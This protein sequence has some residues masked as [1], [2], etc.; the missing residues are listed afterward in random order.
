M[1]RQIVGLVFF[2]LAHFGGPVVVMAGCPVQP[3]S[4][5]CPGRGRE[6][7]HPSHSNTNKPS[8]ISGSTRGVHEQCQLCATTDTHAVR[9]GPGGPTVIRTVRVRTLE[10]CHRTRYEADAERIWHDRTSVVVSARRCQTCRRI[11]SS[12]QG[13]PDPRQAAR[14]GTAPHA[15]IG[16]AEMP[17]IHACMDHRCMLSFVP[18]A[19]T[20]SPGGLPTCHLPRSNS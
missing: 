15:W 8:S 19:P 13:H 9:L 7:N 16:P 14:P 11:G 2:S 3:T 17:R 18:V 10:M 1:G 4:H 20:P 5:S 6:T 12:Q